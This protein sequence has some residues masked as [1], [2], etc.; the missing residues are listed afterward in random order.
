MKK[1]IWDKR[2]PTLLGLLVISLAIGVTSY[3]V[4]QSTFFIGRASPSSK[5]TNIR[6]TNVSDTSFTVSYSTDANALGTL[7]YGD[8]Q[9]LG[10]KILDERDNNQVVERKIHSFTVKNL[11]PSTKYYFSITSGQ[12]TFLNNGVAFELTTGSP[13]SV[14]GSVGFVTG[15]VVTNGGQSPKEAIVYMTTQGSQ[16]LS[17]VVKSDGTYAFSFEQ[18]RSDDLASYFKLKNDSL[19]KLLVVGDS[20]SSSPEFL[21]KDINTVPTIILSQNYD[22]R[23]EQSASSSASL[24]RFPI[25]SSGKSQTTPKITTPSESQNFSDQKPVFKGTGIPN[26]KVRITIQSSETISSETIIDQNGNWTFTPTAPLSP[27]QHSITIFA[28][29]AFGIVRTITQ[30]FVVTAAAAGASPSP[31][32]T[33]TPTPIPSP[34]VSPTPVGQ[35]VSAPSATP[36]PNPT[37][38]LIPTPTPLPVNQLPPTGNFDTATGVIGIVVSLTGIV[39]LFISLVVL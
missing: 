4:G 21:A 12:E 11:S 39:F 31:T 7:N 23:Q 35:T 27:G 34:I 13:I 22:F 37:P 1:T 38:I 3:L 14:K 26:D 15:K 6:V 20:G 36:T 18:L 32:P 25:V 19:I 8:S 10:Q 9:N 2:I 16:A 30:T 29:D 28:K 17:T 24:E 33:P 5:P